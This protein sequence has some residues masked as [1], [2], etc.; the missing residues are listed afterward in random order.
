MSKDNLISLQ[1][2]AADLESGRSGLTAFEEK[3]L[4]HLVDLLVEER[5]GL[6]KMADK[7]FP[8]VEKA[9]E[10][11]E[12]NPTLVP[13]YI[14]VAEMRIDLQAVT[15]LTELFRRVEKIYDILDDSIL[16]CGSEAFKAALKFYKAIQTA[17]KAGVPGA[18]VIYLDL[19]QRFEKAKAKSTETTTET[20]A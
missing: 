13:S 4:P 5:K 16:L 15:T 14:D 20:G 3:I 1:I 12:T 8:F 18:E 17:A 7:T 9:L 11:A 6:P 19:K 10:Y 2:P